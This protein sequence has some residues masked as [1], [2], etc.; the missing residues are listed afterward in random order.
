MIVRRDYR[1]P[2]AR[3]PP[4]RPGP[5]R[6]GEQGSTEDDPRPAAVRVIR[7]TAE[8][9]ATKGGTPD[10]P[11]VRRDMRASLTSR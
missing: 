6:V 1:V 8:P 5:R 7:G 2:G 11:D 3:R 4:E 9:E 10:S